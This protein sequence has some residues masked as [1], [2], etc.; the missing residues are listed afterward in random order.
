MFQQE[1]IKYFG[2]FD[3]EEFPDFVDDAYI[4]GGKHYWYKAVFY[5]DRDEV[6]I[7]DTCD[8]HMPIVLES[9]QEIL[10]MIYSLEQ[11]HQALVRVE[12]E[13]NTFDRAVKLNDAY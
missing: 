6:T 1:M 7:Y 4:V 9:L 8:R 3:P 2:Q 13:F 10:S 12:R 5:P 11:Y